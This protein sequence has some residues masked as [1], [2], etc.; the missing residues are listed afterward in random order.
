MEEDWGNGT[1]CAY[2]VDLGLPSQ[3]VVEA[4]DCHVADQA[5]PTPAES[6]VPIV[7]PCN[8]YGVQYNFA[9]THDV[10]IPTRGAS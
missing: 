5:L 7:G 9:Q 6:P 10:S 3:H 8:N 1:R 4:R 2:V